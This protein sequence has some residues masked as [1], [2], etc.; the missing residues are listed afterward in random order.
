MTLSLIFF[1]IITFEVLFLFFNRSSKLR[2]SIHMCIN[3]LTPIRQPPGW[4]SV[5]LPNLA[6]NAQTKEQTL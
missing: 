5:I 6:S 1:G 2:K 4:G 3:G